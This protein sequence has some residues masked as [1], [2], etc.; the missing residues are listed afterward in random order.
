M[1]PSD[2]GT[3]G[4]DGK[5]QANALT[6]RFGQKSTSAEDR[7]TAGVWSKKTSPAIAVARTKLGLLLGMADSGNYYRK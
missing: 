7:Y 1:R 4:R 6:L 3:P 2:E 5:R